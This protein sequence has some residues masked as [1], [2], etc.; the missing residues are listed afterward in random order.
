MEMMDRLTIE[1]VDDYFGAD[2]YPR[3]AAAL[4]LIELDG[5]ERE[6]VAAVELATALC[7]AAGARTVRQATDAA[8]RALLWKGRKSA[9]SA[10]GRR[11][12]SYY[13]Q[14]GVV[15]RSALPRVLAAIEE[16]SASH[17]MPVANVFHAGDGNLHPLILYS[18]QE[19]GIQERVQ[20]LGAAILRLC[21]DA[22]GSITGEHGVGSDK[23]CYLDWMYG[24]DDLATM[25]LVRQAFDPARL[26]NPGK[27]FPTPRSCGESARRA[28]VL[29][30][31]G[32]AL[33]EQAVAF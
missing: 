15:P 4:L 27:I 25:Q 12:P 33:P 5:Q 13:L 3:D 19:P 31:Q 8:E 2:E 29:Q 32:K 28:E 11:F 21:V 23:R 30:A 10:L 9:I 1:A 20:A 22:G 18:A 16:L 7:Q 6:V 24:P 14:D 17:G 26:A